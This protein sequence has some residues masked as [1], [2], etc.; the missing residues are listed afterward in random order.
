MRRTLS[1]TLIDPSLAQGRGAPWP[2]EAAAREA[3]ANQVH[4]A[5]RFPE[6]LFLGAQGALRMQDLSLGR[7]LAQ[8]PGVHGDEGVATDEAHLQG[9]HAEQQVAVGTGGLGHAGNSWGSAAQGAK[10]MGRM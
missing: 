10:P 4:A 5:Q 7:C 8:H 2:W 9:Q 3:A 1:A 6:V